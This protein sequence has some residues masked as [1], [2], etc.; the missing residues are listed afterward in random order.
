MHMP[1]TF[2]TEDLV[3]QVMARFDWPAP[4]STEDDLPDGVLVAF[5]AC[6]LYFSESYGGD[7]ELDFLEASPGLDRG[8]SL[9]DALLAL[10][11]ESERGD[12][13][14]TPGLSQSYEPT[15]S[16]QKVRTGLDDI[17]RILQHHFLPTLMGE[18]PWAQTQ[19][20]ASQA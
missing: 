20:R 1:P 3:V 18:V 5:P 10:V 15:A 4:Y 16:P 6:V 19:T 7:V 2:L 17:C 13:P 14:L 9:A 8:F 11:P 12:G